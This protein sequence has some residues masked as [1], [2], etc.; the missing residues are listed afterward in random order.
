MHLYNS[1]E[2]TSSLRC[3]AFRRLLKLNDDIGNFVLIEKNAADVK[4]LSKEWK[5]NLK[6][7]QELYKDCATR[8]LNNKNE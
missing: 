3:L 2:N 4:A 6:E 5:I 8:L 7:R 1:F